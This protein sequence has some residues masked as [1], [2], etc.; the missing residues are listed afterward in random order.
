MIRNLITKFRRTFNEKVVAPR[1]DFHVPI[2]I[3]LEPDRHTG[4]LQMPSEHLSISGETKDLSATGIGFVVASIRLKENYLVGEGRTLNAE[5]DLPGG[6]VKMQIIGLRH[7]QFGKHIST[8]R[9][10]VGAKITKISE[11]DREVYEDFLRYGKKH[12]KQSL[13]LGIDES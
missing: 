3:W 8:A 2:K 6:K 13:A 5:L 11:N 1:K 9:F 4:K 7:E 12:L 10:L